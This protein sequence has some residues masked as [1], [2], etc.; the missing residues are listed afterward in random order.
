MILLLVISLLLPSVHPR[1]SF[2]DEDITVRWYVH[3][4]NITVEYEN[5]KV[6]NNQWTGIGFGRNMNNLE[7]IIAIIQDNK[8]SLVTGFTSGYE[9]PILDSHAYVEP[10]H[11][12]FTGDKLTVQLTRPLKATG[13]RNHSLE[14]C[15]TWNFVKEGLYKDGQIMVHQFTQ[16]PMAVCPSNCT[17][18]SENSGHTVSGSSNLLPNLW[19]F[20]LQN[21]WLLSLILY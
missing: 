5:R 8:P 6:T 16:V 1:C 15:Q 21:L 3:N 20:Q 12:S 9:A 10:E 7:V 17:K 18:M 19:M 2:S 14:G 4:D 13:A 11:L